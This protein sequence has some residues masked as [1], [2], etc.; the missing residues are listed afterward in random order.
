MSDTIIAYRMR[1]L[2]DA[3]NLDPLEELHEEIERLVDEQSALQGKRDNWDARRKERRAAI[4][5]LIVNELKAQKIAPPTS[6]AA[7][8]RIACGDPRYTT[9][10]DDA[11]SDFA[12]LAVLNNK[13]QNLRDRVARGN[14]LARV[15]R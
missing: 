14:A 1:G 5:A 3:L 13:I 6:E 2:E 15:A 12:R 9:M 11:E 4:T 7:L 10:L 8:E